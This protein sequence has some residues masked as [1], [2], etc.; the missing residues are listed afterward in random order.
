MAL[1]LG[2]RIKRIELDANYSEY[3]GP[4]YRDQMFKGKRVSTIVSNHVTFVDIL[5]WNSVIFPPSYAAASFV[6]DLPV[7]PLYTDSMTCI[8]IE[9]SASKEGLQKQLEEIKARQ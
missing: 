2:Y 9:R 8:Y 4:N 3:L 1:G 6:K 5:V 7:G